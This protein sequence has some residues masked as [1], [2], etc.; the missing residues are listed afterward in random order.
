MIYR[1]RSIKE[2]DG[3]VASCYLVADMTRLSGSNI[4]H[5]YQPI[6]YNTLDYKSRTMFLAG[7]LHS[8]MVV[9]RQIINVFSVAGHSTRRGAIFPCTFT[10]NILIAPLAALSND[11]PMTTSKILGSRR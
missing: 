10:P 6:M 3:L 2:H 8:F 5:N 7:T 4:R 11:L 1:G 9:I